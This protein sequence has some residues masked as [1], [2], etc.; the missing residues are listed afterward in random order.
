MKDVDKFKE[1]MAILGEI[2]KRDFTEGTI[3]IYWEVLKEYSDKEAI[4]ALDEAIRSC[5]FFPKPV[6]LINII[7]KL[8]PKVSMI[9]KAS[10]QADRIIKHLRSF[11]KSAIPVYDDQIT[12][13]LMTGRWDYMNWCTYVLSS[14]I[15]WW[16][17]EFVNN[18][19][20]Y[21]NINTISETNKLLAY[22]KQRQ[23]ETD[24]I[25]NT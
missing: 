14:E 17:K 7:K 2:H 4:H 9:D 23:I 22:E 5:E 12:E 6:N 20:S 1:R 18:Y 13:S 15:Q 10:E 25:S 19:C 8:Y 21:S 16:K 24:Y 11:G 3:K